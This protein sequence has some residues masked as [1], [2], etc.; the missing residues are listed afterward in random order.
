MAE[1]IGICSEYL[2]NADWL[3]A[4]VSPDDWLFANRNDQ[5]TDVFCTHHSQEANLD[6][7]RSHESDA[8]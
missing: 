1:S 8:G 7:R 2:G 5:N 6:W 4:L 3:T